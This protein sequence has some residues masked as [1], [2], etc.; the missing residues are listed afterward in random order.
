L[1]ATFVIVADKAVGG[2]VAAAEAAA[3]RLAIGFWDARRQFLPEGSSLLKA[4]AAVAE[5]A[6]HAAANDMVVAIGDGADATTSGA[7][8]DS[9][10]LLQELLKH[11]WRSERPALCPLVSPSAVAEAAEAGVGVTIT[12]MI[13][14]V[15]D[16][17]FAVPLQVT[18]TVEKVFE[19]KFTIAR[20]HFNGLK[21]DLGKCATLKI[22]GDDG[23]DT[24]VRV[25]LTT[26]VG[27]HFAIEMFECGGYNP[28]EASVII[29]KSPAGFRSTYGVDAGMLLSADAPGCAA[30]RFW[31]P[32]YRKE[33]LK[34]VT[35]LFPF[36]D[37][38][39]F[40][41]AIDI[42]EA[43]IVTAAG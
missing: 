3:T 14:G 18:A 13:G 2:S 37:I 9:T 29:C 40:T 41:P 22:L 10:W 33:F 42:F 43:P 8:G 30:P 16:T 20:G 35:P 12:T 34:T 26:G 28:F 1:G 4:A 15:R 17:R 32:E 27:A 31:D 21:C 36:D 23:A 38:A 6:A 24:N 19:G 7:P 25:I 39:E 5:A 11:S